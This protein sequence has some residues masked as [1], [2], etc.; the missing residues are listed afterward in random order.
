MKKYLVI[1]AVIGFTVFSGLIYGV[2][3]ILDQKEAVKI[4]YEVLEGD[5]AV[6]EGISFHVRNQW[7]G[8][9][10]WDSQVTLGKGGEVVEMI[11]KLEERF[12]DPTEETYYSYNRFYEKVNMYL[13]HNG[14][15]VENTWIQASGC[16]EEVCREML[17]KCAAET[18]PG[19]TKTETVP[20]KEY[21]AYYDL[22]LN[23][24]LG[25]GS[26]YVVGD[27]WEMVDKWFQIKIPDSHQMEV[28][29]QKDEQGEIIMQRCDCAYGLQTLECSA[30][31][32]ADA[33]YFVFY[34]VDTEGQPYDLS[35]ER[36][37]GIFCIPLA[38]VEE[39]SK[40]VYYSSETIVNYEKAKKA[41]LL[42]DKD[43]YPL[44][45]IAD[46]EEQVLYLL[47][48]EQ[49]KAVLRIIDIK[50][51]E[52]KQ[53][54]ELAA[55]P[56]HGTEQQI[57]VLEDGLVVLLSD[58]SFCY[59][60]E[61]NGVLEKKIAVNLGE[62]PRTSDGKYWYDLVYQDG[63]ATLLIAEY[64]NGSTEAYVY[65]LSEKGVVYKAHFMPSFAYEQYHGGSDWIHLRQED[66]LEIT[67]E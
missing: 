29:V 41:F 62:G 17:E 58:N 42:P 59:L 47:T 34:G 31:Q 61:E 49:E 14:F 10:H 52:E 66:P 26:Y 11:T 7:S 65:V 36:G 44:E 33:V 48:K 19:E 22:Y 21:Q 54:L 46:E 64:G 9:L 40:S 1:L 24:N 3:M 51:M 67:V 60:E 18:K 6:A 45:L 56:Y 27:E 37:N 25:S 35:L 16:D 2:N 53:K 4:E 20:L 57:D 50:T 8:K 63:K 12:A 38:P 32:T 43:C 30:V 5:P 55:N 28:T 23:L 13:E 39:E 15:A